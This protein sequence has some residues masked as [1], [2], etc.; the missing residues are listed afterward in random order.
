MAVKLV[1]HQNAI[2]HEINESLEKYGEKDRQIYCRK[3]HKIT[4]PNEEDCR[5]C[6][7]MA[8]WMQGRGH[9]CAWEDV[10]DTFEEVKY[11]PHEDAQKEL[12]RVSQLIDAGVIR[13][14][15]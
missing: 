8:G 5:N 15:V 7:C 4:E 13:K 3:L 10:S 2:G 9:E 11:I 6:P 1:L 12:F 14:E